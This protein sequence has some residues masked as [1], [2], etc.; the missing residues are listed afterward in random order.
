MK[1][2][3]RKFGRGNAAD[4][5]GAQNALSAMGNIILNLADRIQSLEREKSELRA[6]I[7]ELENELEKSYDDYCS[8]FER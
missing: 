1:K 7:T 5:A 6:R 8:I 4:R 3:N 2:I